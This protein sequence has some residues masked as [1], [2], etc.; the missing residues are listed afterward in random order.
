MTVNGFNPGTAG[1]TNEFPKL[2]ARFNEDPARF[3]ES[4]QNL[5]EARIAGIRNPELLKAYLA[6]EK[7][8]TGGSPREDITDALDERA[9]EIGVDLGIDELTEDTD[10]ATPDA[11]ADRVPA[12]D[13]GTTLEYSEAETVD[14]PT[15]PDPEPEPEPE[16]TSTPVHPDVKGL[17]AGEVLVIERGDA[18]EYV[19]PATADQ[20]APYLSCTPDAETDDPRPLTFD[21]VVARLEGATEPE[22]ITEIDVD[23]PVSAATGGDA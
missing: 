2:E 13:G 1:R 21:K 8:I 11:S 20:D 15:Q 3:L 18:R 14:E 19:F 12:T 22:S 9:A 6:V 7:A 16:T 5:A 23:A 17:D 4:N 10:A